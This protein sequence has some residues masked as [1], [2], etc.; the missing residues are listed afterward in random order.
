M[1][2]HGLR[3]CLYEQV[4][5]ADLRLACLGD[6]P[7]LGE[8][9]GRVDL[10]VEAELRD[11]LALG[12]APGD[13]AAD[14]AQR[15][16][17]LTVGGGRRGDR[18]SGR[19]LRRR[20]GRGGLPALGVPLD[21]GERDP[22]A[23]AGARHRGERDLEALG[24]TA[25]DRSG[26]QPAIRGGSGGGARNRSG[27]RDGLGGDGPA[28][29]QAQPRRRAV[30]HPRRLQAPRASRRAPPCRRSRPRSRARSRHAGRRH[31][32]APCR[33]R[34]R[35]ADRPRRRARRLRRGSQRPH[36]RSPLGPSAAS[37][38]W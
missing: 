2:Q 20:R 4:V 29:T 35:S 14:D 27:G 5:D 23:R 30:A 8:Q 1:A 28:R 32:S 38:Q 13:G 11:R 34:A 15:L 24:G 18:R 6:P 10:A 22:P 19:G 16:E 3:E 9:P 33:S 36:L 37:P 26:T 25:R 17:R 21:V 7:L 31:R 12:H